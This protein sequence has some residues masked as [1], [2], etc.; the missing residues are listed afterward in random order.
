M[1]DI[2]FL[3]PLPQTNFPYPTHKRTNTHMYARTHAGG[4]FRLVQVPMVPCPV[5]EK[6]VAS[7]TINKHL[8]SCLVVSII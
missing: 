8:E 1:Y 7:A 3:L 4:L 6:E 5:C 2:L